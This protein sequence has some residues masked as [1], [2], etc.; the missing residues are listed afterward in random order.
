MAEPMR[1]SLPSTRTRPDD[2]VIEAGKAE[3]LDEGEG[4]DTS[5]AASTVDAAN[6]ERRIAT[7]R[8][9]DVVYSFRLEKGSRCGIV[10]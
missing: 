3:R 9:S 2:G 4:R 5:R 7:E 6:A 10:C 8:R 1:P